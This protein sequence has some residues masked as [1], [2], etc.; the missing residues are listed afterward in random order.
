MNLPLRSGVIGM[1]LLGKSHSSYLQKN[2]D[3]SLVAAAEIREEA[4]R[5]AEASYKIKVYRDY[6]DMLAQE[7]FDLVVVATPDPL[8]KDPVVACAQAGVRY[9]V[10]EKPLATTVEDGAAM[11]S[12][13]NKAGSKLWVHFANRV[14]PL[15][16]ATRYVIQAGLIGRPVYG[17]A[18]LD[19]NI[20][21]PLR[22][23]GERSR[24]WVAASSTAH[25]LLSHV[26][27][28]LRWFL[29]PA[30]VEAVYAITQHEVLG[31][32]P[33]LFDAYLFFDNGMRVRVKAEWIRFMEPLVEYYICI[34]GDKGTVFYNKL[35]GFNVKEHSLQAN[36]ASGISTEELLR[37][38]GEL[39]K[40]G[41]VA[42]VVVRQ[43]QVMVGGDPMPSLEMAAG[44]PAAT[45]LMDH[46]IASIK[47]GQP[48]PS[49][50]AGNGGLP[51]GEDGLKQ[52]RIVCAII[53]SAR[54][55]REVA[56]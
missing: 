11:L 50:W 46:I 40:R 5:E 39:K 55:R 23:W 10:V 36:F 52:T 18:R 41:I 56:V 22:L 2:K 53:E 49:T 28:S 20:S 30:E 54:L 13:C 16:I 6:R 21:V 31:F 15:D 7:P 4:A 3:T 43:P 32:S 26:S 48:I 29:E 33:D 44:Q 51:T 45:Q 42:H 8:H 34:N 19:D 14:V 35:P 27:D 17:E 1:G 12:A 25:F 24:E 37:H 38:Q 47:E 9:I